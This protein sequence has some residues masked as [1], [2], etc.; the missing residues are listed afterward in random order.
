MDENIKKHNIVE[1]KI[2]SDIIKKNTVRKEL[3]GEIRK[4]ARWAKQLETVVNQR[5]KK[6]YV[7]NIERYVPKIK[8]N[9]KMVLD[10]INDLEA[11][12]KAELKY[13]EQE[14]AD[15]QKT[16]KKE[17]DEIVAARKVLLKAEKGNLSESE[18]EELAGISILEMV[19]DETGEDKT[20]EKKISIPREVLLAKA[21]KKLIKESKD[22]EKVTQE[23]S[24]E[25]KDKILF[26]GEIKRML[27]EREV[28]AE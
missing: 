2:K 28:L 4:V 17:Y 10:L 26:K 3:T 20:G 24:S 11:R 16:Y 18:I 8:K 13:S 7:Q 21:Q 6:R 22:L 12:I 19:K 27:F 5:R 25:Q 23:M 9:K 15:L 1:R 14:I